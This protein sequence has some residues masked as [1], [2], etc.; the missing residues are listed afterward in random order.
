MFSKTRGSTEDLSQMTEKVLTK[1]DRR[2]G[3]IVNGRKRKTTAV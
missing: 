3:V 2:A 1:Y